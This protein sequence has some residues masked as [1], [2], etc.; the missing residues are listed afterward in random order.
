MKICFK[1]KEEKSFD[2]FCK[3]KREKDGYSNQCKS[4][5]KEYHLKNREIILE[6]R[7]EYYLDN[8]EI[9]SIKQ[10]EYY[11]E[12]KD[13]VNKKHR[14]HY[15]N[16]KEKISNVKKIYNI[17]NKDTIK[18]NKKI[19]YQ[20]NKEIIKIKHKEYKR[21]KRQDPLF[22]LKANII[23]IIGTS[24]KNKGYLKKTN[25][26]FILGC[27]LKDFIL[28]IES[29]FD[30]WMNWENY[31]K[32]NGEQEYGWDIDH[33]IPLSSAKNENDIYK[34]N[35]FSNLQPLCSYINRVEKRNKLEYNK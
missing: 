15:H 14:D 6:K 33:I 19:Y 5:A 1:C 32:Y 23:N 24:I 21:I 26:E 20:S 11:L 4:C 16:N 35:H 12:N 29:K 7:K 30:S 31:G 22:R 28:Y 34:L 27:E 13:I 3:N 10:K 2:F 25:T 8:K 17:E 9:F 18:E